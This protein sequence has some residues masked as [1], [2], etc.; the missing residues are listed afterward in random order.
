MLI[1]DDFEIKANGEIS[2]IFL[3]NGITKFSNAAD[4]IKNLPYGRNKDKNNLKTVFDDNCG[5]CSTK[6]ALLKVLAEENNENNLKLKLGI[7]KMNA[8]NTPKIRQTLEQN[9]LKYIPEAHNY[10][11]INDQILDYTNTNS[12]ENDFINDLLIEIDIKPTQITDFKVLYHTN[13]LKKWLEN[14]SNIL[15]NLEQIWQIRE[16]C[17][18]D[19]SQN[20]A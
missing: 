1:F 5:T 8:Q 17:I 15:L 20:N 7:F 10:L 11:K 9:H 13:Y 2:K 16:Q 6:H 19:L 4:F 12:S 14:Q 3:Q 18:K